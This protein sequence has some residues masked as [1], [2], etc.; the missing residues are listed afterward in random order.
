[1]TSTG[2]FSLTTNGGAA[3]YTVGAAGTSLCDPITGLDGMSAVSLE[4]R[5]VYG[6]GGTTA[7]VF[8]QS[9]I[10]QGSN[11]FDVAHAAFTTANGIKLFNV[12]GLVST[13]AA[14]VP[15]DGTLAADTT[16]GGILGDRL[17]V[18]VISAGTYAGNT[19]VSVRAAVR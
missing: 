19:L 18:K 16:Q 1:M 9:S 14:V 7:D 13:T 11:W 17:R 10:D 12:S 8:V 15:A 3:D 6:S 4:V 5:F 2:I